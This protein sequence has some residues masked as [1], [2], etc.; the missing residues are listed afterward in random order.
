[1]NPEMQTTLLN[2]YPTK[3]IA[4]ILKAV[5]EQLEE[6]DQLTAVEE[7]AGSVPEIPLEYDQILKG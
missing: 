7:I 3:L 4:T 6:N 5:R 2:T 1:M